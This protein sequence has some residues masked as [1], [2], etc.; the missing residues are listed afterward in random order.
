MKPVNTLVLLANDSHARFLENHGVGKGLA[1]VEA[2]KKSI[3]PDG[4]IHYSDR[5][6]RTA[7]PSGGRR[8][9]VE[10]H[11]SEHDQMLDAF[12]TSVL[13]ETEVIWNAR[14][15]Q[16]FV[17]AASPKMLGTLRDRLPRPL[18]DA[19]S[20][21]LDKDFLKLGERELVEHF[22]DHIAF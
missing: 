6:G 8:H 1:E 15:Y 18:S 3:L 9:A 11:T 12:A 16:R 20:F 10:P 22:S 21:D 7:A 14:N 4:E 5:R 13:A 2:M 19:L 17:L